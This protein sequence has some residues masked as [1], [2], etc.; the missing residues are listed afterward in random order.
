VVSDTPELFGALDAPIHV[1]AAASR[2]ECLDHVGAGQAGV[3]THPYSP[4][5]PEMSLI[6]DQLSAP[7][8]S[9]RAAS[10]ETVVVAQA[11]RVSKA[12]TAR[13]ATGPAVESP[14]ASTPAGRAVVGGAITVAAKPGDCFDVVFESGPRRSESSNIYCATTADV[15]VL[16]TTTFNA[17]R[18]FSRSDYISFGQFPPRQLHNPSGL[19]DLPGELMAGYNDY[20]RDFSSDKDASPGDYWQQ[21]SIVRGVAEYKVGPLAGHLI[22]SAKLIMVADDYDS[23]VMLPG[24]KVISEAISCAQYIGAF[25]DSN[26]TMP[27]SDHYI[28]VGVG[29]TP[30][31]ADV[32]D[33]VIRWANGAPNAGFVFKGPKE[34]RTFNG[35]DEC[36]SLYRYPPKLVVTYY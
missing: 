10:S 2:A 24:G 17:V 5:G 27:D 30:Y 20:R 22:I 9:R 7:A 15:G 6:W 31:A 26:A 19:E 35:R 8:L 18:V 16:Q 21:N 33:I 32:T 13:G 25:T 28:D 4:P 1:R 36:M 12:A 29:M 11:Y 3:C 34:D 14:G 23:L